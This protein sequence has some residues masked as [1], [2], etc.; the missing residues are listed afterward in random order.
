MPR[1]D[2]TGPSGKGSMT[3]RG[4]GYCEDGDEN[5]KNYHFCCGR[6]CCGRGRFLNSSLSG[7]DQ[8]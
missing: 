1:M 3:G 5:A 2:K 6:R 8:K 7:K 4:R